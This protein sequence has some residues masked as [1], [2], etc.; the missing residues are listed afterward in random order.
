M[1]LDF[2][3]SQIIFV[4]YL[5]GNGG[6][7]LARIISMSPEIYWGDEFGEDPDF[8]STG[9]V[10]YPG[11]LGEMDSTGLTGTIIGR[12]LR[13]GRE[14][15]GL[16]DTPDPEYLREA[17]REAVKDIESLPDR[18]CHPTHI[19]P[20]AIRA[21]FPNAHIVDIRETSQTLAIRLLYEK[22]WK[23]NIELQVNS[24]LKDVKS[25]LRDGGLYYRDLFIPD[26]R[27]YHFLTKTHLRYALERRK[28]IQDIPTSDSLQIG[29]DRL[30]SGKSWGCVY[31]EICEY[32]NITPQYEKVDE[33]MESYLAKQWRRELLHH[34]KQ[35]D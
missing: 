14:T 21:A 11:L 24:H 7:S 18:F 10:H 25:D 26:D 5:S 13:R 32:L 19:R 2:E 20:T 12:D 17:F 33:Y 9:R 4:C 23:G 6:N 16:H 3:S 27:V 31:R 35:T 30:F 34:K 29:Y 8:D 1:E 22:L 28:V 15:M